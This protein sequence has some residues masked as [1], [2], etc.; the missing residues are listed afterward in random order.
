MA[1]T[2]TYV[3]SSATAVGD[4]A[5]IIGTVDNIP[6]TGPVAINI[7]MN[8]S[9]IKQAQAVSIAALEALVGPQMLQ[10]ATANGLVNPTPPAQITQ[11]PTGTFTL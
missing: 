7:Q 2:H 6:S 8:Y 9:A 11:L 3:V 4:T 10:A 1:A 5:T